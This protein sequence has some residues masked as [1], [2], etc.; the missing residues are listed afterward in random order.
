MPR[1]TVGLVPW[2]T[3]KCKA[4]QHFTTHKSENQN[5]LLFNIWHMTFYTALRE[6]WDCLNI[7]KC[8]LLNPWSNQ[9]TDILCSICLIKHLHWGQKNCFFSRQFSPY[10]SLFSLCESVIFHLSFSLLTW[11][12]TSAVGGV[13][14]KAPSQYLPFALISP[15]HHLIFRHGG[16]SPFVI[17]IMSDGLFLSLFAG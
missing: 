14:S 10:F 5:L 13:K 1:H 3:V 2:E 4:I 11:N 16:I 17:A 9:N 15:P 7:H 6:I 8:K 12:T